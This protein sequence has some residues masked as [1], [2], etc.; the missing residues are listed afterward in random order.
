MTARTRVK[1]NLKKKK[2]SK[3]WDQNVK[4]FWHFFYYFM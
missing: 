3:L 4:N 2:Q 1:L